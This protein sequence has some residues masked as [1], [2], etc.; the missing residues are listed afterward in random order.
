[1]KLLMLLIINYIIYNFRSNK[2]NYNE[3]A[4]NYLKII[5]KD[6]FIKDIKKYLK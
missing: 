2:T 4:L 6:I 3:L 5:K 1:M